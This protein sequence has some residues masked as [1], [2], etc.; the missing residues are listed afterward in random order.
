MSKKILEFLRTRWSVALVCGGVIAL[1]ALPALAAP[2]EAV[3]DASR[4]R[5]D[6]TVVPT[7][8]ARLSGAGSGSDVDSAW[9]TCSGGSLNI[10]VADSSTGTD[11]AGATTPGHK[12]VDTIT[13]RG[14]LTSGRKGNS[15]QLEPVTNGGASFA[16]EI[17][18]LRQVSL[19]VESI[20]MEDLVIDEREMTTGADWDYRVSGPGDA[21]FG[22]ITIRS[23]TSESKELYQWWLEASKGKDIRKHIS[24]II[25]KRDGSEARRYNYLECFPVSY[26]P[27]S[28]DQPGRPATEGV[29]ARCDGLTLHGKDQEGLFDW[30]S[31]TLAGKEARRTL[32]LTDLLTEAGP[33]GGFTYHDAFPVRYVFPALQA[34]GTGNL[35][36][37]VH[38]KPIRLELK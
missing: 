2:R 36:E 5:P 17:E 29:V 38:I 16:L 14:P 35:Y 6:A 8:A 23:R 24:V 32:Q 33:G 25:K 26:M 9:E 37:E 28:L 27:H 30:I 7:C 31:E 13:L 10:E 1:L 18:G 21:H 11:K 34:S 19:N 20:T 22:S 4:A 3:L 12:Y 15:E